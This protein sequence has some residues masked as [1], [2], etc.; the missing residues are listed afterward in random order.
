MW[1]LAYGH[2]K[3]Q[4]FTREAL[5]TLLFRPGQVNENDSCVPSARIEA[6]G[7]NAGLQQSE[8]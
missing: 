1:T 3:L 8:G 7:G 2:A 5:K 4:N 6:H